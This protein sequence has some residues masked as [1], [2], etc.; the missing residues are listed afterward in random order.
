MRGIPRNALK[1]RAD[2]E[3]L[4]DAALRDELRPHEVAEL[5]RHWQAL[6]DGRFAYE[7]DRVLGEDE[8]PDGDEPEYRVMADEDE[9][10]GEV[11]RTQYKLVESECS[12]M[13]RMGFAALDVEMALSELE[14]K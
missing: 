9:D 11:V 14:G 3:M 7:V 1:T 8:V 13:H 12:R 4:H 10:T 2:F 6:L 5:R